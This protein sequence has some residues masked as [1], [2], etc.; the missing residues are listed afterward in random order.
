VASVSSIGRPAVKTYEYDDRY[1]RQQHCAVSQTAIK[2]VVLHSTEGPTAEGGAITLSSSSDVSAHL[3][4]GKG[5]TYRIVP[6]WLGSCTV[7]EPNDWT[8]NIEQV[9]FAAWSRKK[10]L[11]H[12]NTIKRAAFWTAWW[13][14]K[15]KL[16]RRFRNA[17]AL[18]AGEIRG[19]TTHAQL[20][21][22]KW[23]SSTHTDPGPNYPLF[24][25]VSFR[26]LLLYYRG[27]IAAGLKPKQAA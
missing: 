18:D 2:L 19:Y 12:L 22:S 8:L 26:A 15:H 6:E 20:S 16:P 5:V 13:C 23:S 3:C 14:K 1:F 10:W 4:V 7:Q 17:K 21:L 25:N 11:Q 27:R 24:G 9:G